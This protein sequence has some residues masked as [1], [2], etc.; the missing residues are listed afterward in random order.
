ML[1]QAYDLDIGLTSKPGSTEYLGEK[2]LLLMVGIMV[3][4]RDDRE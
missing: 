1:L 4:L 2:T 3:L